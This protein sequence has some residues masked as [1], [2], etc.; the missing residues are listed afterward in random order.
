MG[1]RSPDAL[2]HANNIVLAAS[3][4]QGCAFRT[5][6][7][8]AR[9]TARSWGDFRGLP[10][11]KPKLPNEAKLV[12]ASRSLLCP[13]DLH[14]R[15]PAFYCGACSPTGT[16]GPPSAP[17]LVA[18]PR[19]AQVVR[20]PCALVVGDPQHAPVVRRFLVAISAVMVK[21][22]P[23]VP[24]CEWG[25]F[26]PPNHLLFSPGSR[27]VLLPFNRPSGCV[28]ERGTERS[29]M[30]FLT[31]IRRLA[32]HPL[33]VR[34]WSRTAGVRFSRARGRI[35]RR[36]SSKKA[37]LPNEAKL[38]FRTPIPLWTKGLRPRPQAI[39]ANG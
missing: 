4:P 15:L 12:S 3:I 7:P 5:L 20:T 16:L 23:R 21:T 18:S 17:G 35:D 26:I 30:L 2:S 28:I 8:A 6:A 14:S 10:V 36:P 38:V 33:G 11:K 19:G 39:P 37:K 25:T 29:P 32:A 34:A 1:D 13:S 9:R 24:S 31:R 22:A 27:V